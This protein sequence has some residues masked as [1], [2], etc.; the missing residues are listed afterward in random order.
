M[1]LKEMAVLYGKCVS[2]W[3]FTDV[4]RYMRYSDD[5]PYL[6]SFVLWGVGL[7]WP[8]NDSYYGHFN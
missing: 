7:K 3:I 2:L 4:N 5:N 6:S 1:I 8:E